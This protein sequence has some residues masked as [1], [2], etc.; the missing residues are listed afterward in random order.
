MIKK[1]VSLKN[2]K[3]VGYVHLLVHLIHMKNGFRTFNEG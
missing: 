1:M 3:K 2:K